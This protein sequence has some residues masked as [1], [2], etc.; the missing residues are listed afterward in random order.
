MGEPL[1][2]KRHGKKFWQKFF[3]NI[4]MSLASFT[5]AGLPSETKPRDDVR[6]TP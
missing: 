1:C 3:N 2:L 5:A 6:R 4:I